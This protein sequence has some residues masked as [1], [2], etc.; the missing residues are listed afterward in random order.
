MNIELQY[1][2]LLKDILENGKDKVPDII[3]VA[4]DVTLPIITGAAGR[5]EEE[6]K[7]RKENLM[8]L[9]PTCFAYKT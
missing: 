2:E 8:P 4:G 3:F 1:L 6:K 5:T 7:K 9:K